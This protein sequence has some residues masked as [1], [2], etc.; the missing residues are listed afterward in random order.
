[1]S[2]HHLNRFKAHAP[3]QG[4]SSTEWLLAYHFTSEA[5]L[6]T[7]LFSESVSRLA[8]RFELHRRTIQKSMARLVELGLFERIDRTGTHAPIYRLLV[9]CPEN[10]LDLETHNAP[11]E[12]EVI[13]SQLETKIA[14]HPLGGHN[15]PPLSALFATPYKEE[16]EEEEKDLSL[17]IG[18]RELSFV[19][20]ALENQNSLTEG[21]KTLLEFAKTDPHTIAAKAV[22]LTEK[23]DTPK[24]KQAYLAKI[25]LKDPETLSNAV[26]EQKSDLVSRNLLNA[27]RNHTGEDFGLDVEI[28]EERLEQFLDETYAW[29][30]S[31]IVFGNLLK[32]AQDEKKLTSFDV[33]ITHALELYVLGSIL[34]IM[35][36]DLQT[37]E[38]LHWYLTLG[39][40]PETGCPEF[41]GDLEKCFNET[42]PDL[43]K[44][45]YTPS[46]RLQLKE[47]LAGLEK[48]KATHTAK[49]GEFS[50]SQFWLETDTRAFLQLHPQPV[51][52]EEQSIRF[53]K[54]LNEVCLDTY[55]P[56]KQSFTITGEYLEEEKFSAWLKNNYS[57]EDDFLSFLSCLPERE[58]GSHAK[59]FRAAFPAYVEARREFDNQTLKRLAL[60]YGDKVEDR[61]YAKKPQTFLNEILGR[62][63]TEKTAF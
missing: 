48:L 29:Q 43:I 11:N 55:E 53:I 35:R 28:T 21:Q 16:R 52:E 6:K 1:M 23:L 44:Q 59:N 9:S 58:T 31:E 37:P 51:T 45:I 26:L 40:N 2:Y 4:L 10:C 33:M 61:T 19:I 46:E 17:E 5:R 42:H 56:L 14:T 24:R 36:K 13:Q 22:E 57:L 41:Y 30:P 62:K 12:L 20:G 34:P 60:D 15:T 39:F 50:P 3:T 32:K 63:A 25:A 38:A 18:F 7:S 54:L 49:H 8:D 27:P 47:H